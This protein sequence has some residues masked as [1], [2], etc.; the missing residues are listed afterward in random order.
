VFFPVLTG[1]IIMLIVAL[2]VNNIAESR[3]YP[4]FWW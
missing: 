1:V 3:K 4:E 2:V